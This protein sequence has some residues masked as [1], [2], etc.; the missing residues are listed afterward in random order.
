MDKSWTGKQKRAWRKRKRQ[1]RKIP[2][3]TMCNN[4]MH[5]NKQDCIF[6]CDCDL[7]KYKDDIILEIEYKGIWDQI[8]PLGG[9]PDLDHLEFTPPFEVPKQIEDMD[10]YAYIKG[11]E[12]MAI[13]SSGA[14]YKV[15]MDP[16][17]FPKID[18]DPPVLAS[19]TR[20]RFLDSVSSDEVETSPYN[21]VGALIHKV[22]DS[23]RYGTGTVIESYEADI[24]DEKNKKQK[25]WF[26]WVLTAG[27]V[28]YRRDKIEKKGVITYKDIGILYIYIVLV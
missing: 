13:D 19:N 23:T 24:Y 15:T 5:N 7:A 10:D 28:L 12:V 3:P 8:Y 18:E 14:V 1:C 11:I 26:T 4:Q 22:G 9:K 17:K 16:A 20:R 2:N 6:D 25:E 27:H 21:A